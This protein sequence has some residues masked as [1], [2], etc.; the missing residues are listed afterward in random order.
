MLIDYKGR[1]IVLLENM[2]FVVK[3]LYEDKELI[4]EAGKLKNNFLSRIYFI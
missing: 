4:L 1:N 2:E 3:E